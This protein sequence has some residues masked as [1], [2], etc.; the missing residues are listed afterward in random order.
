MPFS[1]AWRRLVFYWIVASFLAISCTREDHSAVHFNKIVSTTLH[2]DE[3]LVHLVH[4]S[5]ILSLSS[6]ADD[7]YFS[8][9]GEKAQAVALRTPAEPEAI[10]AL[11]PDLVLASAWVAPEKVEFLRQMGLRIEVVPIPQTAGQIISQTLEL[12]TFLRAE[13]QAGE[14][15]EDMN[16][17]KERLLLRNLKISQ[18]KT[19]AEISEWGTSGGRGSLWNEMCNLAGLRNLAA[20]QE[21]DKWGMAQISSE[22]LLLWQPDLVYLAE[23][24]GNTWNDSVV[25]DPVFSRLEAVKEQRFLTIPEAHRSSPGLGFWLG[26]LE[27]SLAAY[28]EI[29]E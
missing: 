2:T 16:S 19:L 1:S 27:L 14:L 10:M 6:L 21:S 9:L 8:P 20:E 25:S 5:R 15:V 7:D 17:M 3:L 24:P 11:G 29:K 4:P 23:S 26:A 28:P 13:E 18:S 22:M 12:G